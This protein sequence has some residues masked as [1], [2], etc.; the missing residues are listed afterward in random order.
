MTLP[1]DSRKIG[2]GATFAY[3]LDDGRYSVCRIL[4]APSSH[5]PLES[6]DLLLAK[7]RMTELRLA[8]LRNAERKLCD[9]LW[10]EAF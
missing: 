2:A 4:H 8:E 3:P 6:R 10:Q 5:R 7:A 9:A 1:Q